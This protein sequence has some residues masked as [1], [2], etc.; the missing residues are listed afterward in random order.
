MRISSSLR[1]MS[2]RLQPE[3]ITSLFNLQPTESWNKGDLIEAPM[4]SASAEMGTWLFQSNGLKSNDVAEHLHWLLTHI[5][6][7]RSAIKELENDGH[8]VDVSCNVFSHGNLYFEMSPLLLADFADIGLPIDFI[9][10]FEPSDS[11][12]SDLD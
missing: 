4:G 8:H 6:P 11:P 9:V 1:I 7:L 12:G 3:K 2:D 10:A 5:R